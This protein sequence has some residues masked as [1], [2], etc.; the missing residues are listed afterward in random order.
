MFRFN[1]ML[2]FVVASLCAGCESATPPVGSIKDM[3]HDSTN[4]G[5]LRITAD[6]L[7]SVPE[8]STLIVRVDENDEVV[9]FDPSRGPI[10]FSRL[11]IVH[12]NGQQMRMDTWLGGVA[13]K[14]ITAEVL[15][16]S[17]FSVA[18]T[19]KT[20]EE[21]FEQTYEDPSASHPMSMPGCYYTCCGPTEACLV[22]SGG[23]VICVEIP[24]DSWC[25]TC[26]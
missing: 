25:V 24:C 5:Q 2:F 4:V 11:E 15:A 18:L 23:L 6:D 14:G 21:A 16:A 7:R 3:G 20:A 10:D 12:P 26:E 13:Q 17:E 22:L 8:G 9:V 1:A 19:Q